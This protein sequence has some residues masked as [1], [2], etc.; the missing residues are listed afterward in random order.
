VLVRRFGLDARQALTRLRSA[1][2][3]AQPLP[4]QLAALLLW[5]G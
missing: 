2:P 4:E 1:R 5:L 3:E